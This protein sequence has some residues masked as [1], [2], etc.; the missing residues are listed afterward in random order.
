MSNLVDLYFKKVI[1]FEDLKIGD[2]VEIVDTTSIL[3]GN[4]IFSAIPKGT[5]VKIK[6]KIEP[7]FRCKSCRNGIKCTYVDYNRNFFSLLCC[8]VTKYNGQEIVSPFH[9]RKVGECNKEE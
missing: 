7:S 6:R 3:S 8:Y 4:E 1:R 2:E 9:K 5:K